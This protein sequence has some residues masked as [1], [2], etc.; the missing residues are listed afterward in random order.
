MKEQKIIKLKGM[1]KN[2]K[3]ATTQQAE[4]VWTFESSG[5]IVKKYEDY[6][7]VSTKRGDY[8]LPKSKS[9]IN[10]YCGTARGTKVHF[11]AKK[12]V[13]KLIYWA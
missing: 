4:K 2:G 7:L 3:A 1:L 5:I 6:V 12:I 8:K 9:V 11:T 13:A 10:L